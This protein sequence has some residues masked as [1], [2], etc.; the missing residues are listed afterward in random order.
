METTSR[1]KAE[2]FVAKDGSLIREIVHPR[3]SGARNQSLAEAT[4]RP[5]AR[6]K[7]HHH[8]R[9]E[10]IYYLLEGE[11]RVHVGGEA[12]EVG[13]TEA[14]IIPPAVRHYIENVGAVDLVFLCCS[15]PSYWDED[16]VLG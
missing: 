4:V 11:G 5:G 2:P 8:G 16:M 1:E 9:S 6:T 10:E 12:R 13:R 7:E 14:I 3:S 15:A